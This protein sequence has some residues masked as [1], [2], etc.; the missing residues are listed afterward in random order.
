MSLLDRVKK[1][2]NFWQLVIILPIVFVA[3]WILDLV[4]EPMHSWSL[5]AKLLALIAVILVIGF[6][7]LS[8]K[9]EQD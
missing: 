2:S 9:K 7:K 6:S 8:A 1:L 3:A 4:M 5:E